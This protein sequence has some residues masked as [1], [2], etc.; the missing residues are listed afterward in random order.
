[1]IRSVVLGSAVWLFPCISCCRDWWW[2]RRPVLLYMSHSHYTLSTSATRTGFLGLIF[3]GFLAIW[4]PLNG[5]ALLFNHNR[6]C[7]CQV[8]LLFFLILVHRQ[9]WAWRKALST[10]SSCLW[11]SGEANVYLLRRKHSDLLNLVLLVY[12]SGHRDLALL[13]LL[14]L[15]T[16][17]QS[18]KNGK[19]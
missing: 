3:T 12:S 19:W 5:V 8:K 4:A 7:P 18:F 16:L 9:L 17:W 10:L 11:L 15:C 14:E 2:C 6:R 1:M 13:E